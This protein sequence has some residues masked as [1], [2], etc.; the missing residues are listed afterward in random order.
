MPSLAR[1]RSPSSAHRICWSNPASRTARAARSATVILARRIVRTKERR[2]G[3]VHVETAQSLHN[4]GL[5][6]AARGEFAQAIPLFERALAIR[7][8]SL[9]ADSADVADTL[10]QLALVLIQLERFKDARVR[11][12]ESMRIRDRRARRRTRSA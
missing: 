1:I 5:V 12:D 8:A 10:D 9:P 4:L 7:R 6:R 3:R 11:L 2:V